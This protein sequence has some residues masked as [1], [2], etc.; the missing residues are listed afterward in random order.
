MARFVLLHDADGEQPRAVNVDRVESFY[1][2]KHGGTV[3]MYQ[4]NSPNECSPY[5]HVKEHFEDVCR[6][7]GGVARGNHT[8]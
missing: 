5:L 4:D 1:P 6:L 2:K 8:P 7:V 3:L